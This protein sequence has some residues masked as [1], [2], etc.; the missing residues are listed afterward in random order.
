MQP[1]N[2]N[3]QM[4]SGYAPAYMGHNSFIV[5]CE[6]STWMWFQ[7]MNWQ[8]PRFIWYHWLVFIVFFIQ[9]DYIVNSKWPE[10]QP[11][12]DV[13]IRSSQYLMDAAHDFRIRLRALQQSKK[14]FTTSEFIMM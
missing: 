5:V 6:Y 9:T 13:L 8:V 1:P 10:T 12:N 2:P 3:S 4:F 11:I 7:L 14:A